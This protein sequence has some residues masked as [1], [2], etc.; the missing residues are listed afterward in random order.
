MAQASTSK[1]IVPVYLRFMAGGMAF[2]IM[3]A[4]T[5]ACFCIYKLDSWIAETRSPDYV[6]RVSH[7][8]ATFAPPLGPRYNAV[9]ALD[10]GSGFKLATYVIGTLQTSKK[11][12]SSQNVDLLQQP[13]I[14]AMTKPIRKDERDKDLIRSL[15]SVG[16]I[17]SF[18]VMRFDKI[19][20]WGQQKLPAGQATLAYCPVVTAQDKPGQPTRLVACLGCI[21]AEKRSF[22]FIG[23]APR[24]Q[25]AEHGA[26]F[27]D[28]FIYLERLQSF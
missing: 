16:E 20:E 27:E 25:G 18:G 28:L 14:I 12:Q 11:P 7:E 5:T 3:F 6:L 1:L 8:L 17:A 26:K 24:E 21:S 2:V 19:V 23:I 13:V 22:S 9:S 4:L 10:L 15:A